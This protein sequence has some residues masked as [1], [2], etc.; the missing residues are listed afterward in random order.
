MELIIYVCEKECVEVR[1]LNES[2]ITHT[3]GD[4]FTIYKAQHI[5]VS[6]Y[7]NLSHS[8]WL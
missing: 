7:V 3:F 5:T 2:V 6:M 4:R 1:Q 8:W